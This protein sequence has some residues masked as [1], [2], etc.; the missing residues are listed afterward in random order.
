VTTIAPPAGPVADQPSGPRLGPAGWLRWGWRTLT[1]MRTALLLLLL[2]ALAAVPG[3]LIPQQSVNPA[4]VT[5]YR[6]AH[7]ELAPWVAR[8]G[9]FHVY[10]SPWFAAVYLLLFTSLVGC[11]VP[12]ARLHWRAAR[13]RPP[14]TPSRLSRLP[15]HRSY[16]VDA[17]PQEVLDRAAATLRAKRF[18][19]DTH[20]GSVASEKG[21]LKE[22]GNL[23]FHLALLALLVTFAVSHLLGFTGNRVV[24]VGQSFGNGQFDSVSY[25][26]SAGPSDVVPFSLSLENL[27]VRYQTSGDQTGA[28]RG[29]DATV[30]W[31]LHGRSGIAH[32]KPNSPLV[33]DG[34]KVFLTGNGY[35]LKFRIRDSTG[36]VVSEPTSVFLPLDGNNTS[37]GAVKVPQAAGGGLVFQGVFFPT[38][39]TGRDGSPTSVYP[40]TLDPQVYLTGYSGVDTSPSV[41]SVDQTGLTA[42]KDAN[43][44][45]WR[46]GVRPGQ[47]ATLPGG[48]GTVQFLGVTRFANF[49]ISNSTGN[50]PVLVSAMLALVGLTGSLLGRQRR[51][52]VR[53]TPDTGGRTVVEV[54][55][56]GKGDSVALAG[57]VEELASAVIQPWRTPGRE[58][59]Q[60][61][62]T[63]SAAGQ[64][65]G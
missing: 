2:L 32:V 1:S 12:R 52:W 33:V 38:P 35:A 46:Q 21:Y 27:S 64:E 44:A 15:V 43:G 6:T 55:G 30:R 10:S 47:T 53:A 28:P 13:S 40:D 17:S 63:V 3:S 5:A 8:L 22:T 4:R 41:Y 11:V 57:E 62:R 54:A 7:P 37:V 18:R 19:V 36:A 25:G 26:A 29:F 56:L 60:H 39:G 50:A 23:V 49:Q 48:K 34:D 20:D 58:H 45:P 42:F 14:L 59:E 9:G 61:D 51:V 31:A 65:H 16:A 24:V